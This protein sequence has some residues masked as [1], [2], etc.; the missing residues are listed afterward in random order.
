[1]GVG[2][3]GGVTVKVGWGV[4]NGVWVGSAAAATN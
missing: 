3:A 2:G 4:L 1:V